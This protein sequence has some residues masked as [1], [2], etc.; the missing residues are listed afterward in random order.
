MSGFVLSLKQQV[1]TLKRYLDKNEGKT[2]LQTKYPPFILLCDTQGMKTYNH[3]NT[4]G[5]M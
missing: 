2:R 5:K 1:V 3:Y 4:H